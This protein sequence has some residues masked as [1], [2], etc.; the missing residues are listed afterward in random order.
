MV[1]SFF[2]HFIF[3]HVPYFDK[4]KKKEKKFSLLE[5][6]RIILKACSHSFPVSDAYCLDA[7]LPPF[8]V[9]TEQLP[10]VISPWLQGI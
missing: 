4:K 8:A 6:K 7:F 2:K 3:E 9:K 5:K 10:F 1:T